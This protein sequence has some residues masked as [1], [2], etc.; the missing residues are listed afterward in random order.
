MTRMT[1]IRI[2]QRNA[3]IATSVAC[4]TLSPDLRLVVG[5]VLAAIPHPMWLDP[6]SCE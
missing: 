2:P 6:P 5:A 3:V 4:S 1:T